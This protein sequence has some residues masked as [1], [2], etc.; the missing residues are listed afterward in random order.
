MAFFLAQLLI[1]YH[2]NYRQGVLALGLAFA[3][4]EVNICCLD[5]S[6]RS[7]L[8]LAAYVPAVSFPATCVPAMYVPTAHVLAA[9]IL[10]VDLP[11]AI[12]LAPGVQ[13]PGHPATVIIVP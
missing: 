3:A 2:L 1:H 13:S 11:A 4:A 8:C 7:W 10:T 5:V 9:D 6:R 12:I